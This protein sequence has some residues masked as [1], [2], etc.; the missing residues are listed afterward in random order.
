[1]SKVKPIKNIPVGS[2]E[3]NLEI[4][5]WEKHDRERFQVLILP[6]TAPFSDYDAIRYPPTIEEVKEAL[7]WIIENES[8]EQLKNYTPEQ[9]KVLKEQI[10]LLIG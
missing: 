10:D 9:V 8:R 5:R 7:D 3:V 4:F 1:M 2:S 6:V